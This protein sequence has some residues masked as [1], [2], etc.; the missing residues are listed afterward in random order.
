MNK[1]F[2]NETF[3]SDVCYKG[4]PSMAGVA[5]LSRDEIMA[6]GAEDPH[7]LGHLFI[8]TGVLIDETRSV[9]Y[10]SILPDE[11]TNEMER[12]TARDPEVPWAAVKRISFVNYL[13]QIDSEK[14]SIIIPKYSNPSESG[15]AQG[16]IVSSSV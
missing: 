9:I 3:R 2:S 16:N 5:G 6:L 8:T 4:I 12:E 11:V 14:Q 13:L 7:D 1:L 10:V 15:Q